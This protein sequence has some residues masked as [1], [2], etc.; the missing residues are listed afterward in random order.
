[1]AVDGVARLAAARAAGL[2]VRAVGTALEVRGP[3]G[4]AAE[5]E[6]LLAA[7]GAVLLALDAEDPA[8]AWRAAAMTDQILAAGPVPFLVARDAPLG[9]WACPSCG[10]PL[11]DGESYRCVLCGR[12]ARLALARAQKGSGR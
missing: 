1:M 5:A 10:E 9:P 8:V 12:A 2:R 3:R 11:R 6:A 7:K 4:A